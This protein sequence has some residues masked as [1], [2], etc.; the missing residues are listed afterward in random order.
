MQT[1]KSDA[2]SGE[3]ETKPGV[4]LPKTED[5]RPKRFYKS[6]TIEK[7]DGGNWR[8]LLD[9]RGVKS[10]AR[11]EL[12]VP[13]KAAA[14]LI[15]GEWDAQGEHIDAPSM[16]A[17]RLAFVTMDRMADARAETAA[18]VAKYASTDL[19]CF[20]AANPADLVAAQNAAWNPLLE[21]A[22]SELG[23]SLKAVAG[24]MPV[25]QDAVALHTVLTRAAALD[26]WKLTALAH[27]TAV[28]GSA[29]LGLALLEGRIDGAQ[30]HALSTVDEA[31]QAANWGA[32]DDAAKRTAL[33][34]AEL[35]VVGDWLRTLDAQAAG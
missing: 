9:G 18:E 17:S 30:A 5:P 34:R 14:E 1:G 33:L 10:P 28:C 27:T 24:V 32:D 26:D 12:A 8:V 35:I 31:F 29:V 21:W 4:K 6:V 13:T 25:Q 23:V 7:G 15:A 2:K 3:F 20:R 19:L 16:P 11:K 22:K